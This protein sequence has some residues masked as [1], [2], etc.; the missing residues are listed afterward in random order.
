MKE[1]TIKTFYVHIYRI[2]A[3]LMRKLYRLTVVNKELEPQEGPCIVCANHT[4]LS[5]VIVLSAS[6]KRQVRYMAKK[7]LFKIPLLSQLITALGAFPIDR[8]NR[9]VSALKRTLALLNEGE[10][11]GIFPQGTRYPRVDPATTPV[12]PGVGMMAYRSKATIL[13]AYIQT[14]NNKTRL[15]KKT[16]V[17]LG[18]PISF[19]ELVGSDEEKRNYEEIA[20]KIFAAICDLSKEE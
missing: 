11:V 20:S 7:E 12:K 9:D 19:E 18:K 17:I 14:K 3:K 16:T 6:M 2:F 1:K 5:D 4:S 15:F 13:P 8:K 10:M